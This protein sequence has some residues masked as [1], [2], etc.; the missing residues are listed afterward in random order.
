MPISMLFFLQLSEVVVCSGE[1]LSGT[2]TE[3]LEL[4]NDLNHAMREA[5]ALHRENRS[6]G[7]IYRDKHFQL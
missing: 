7:H 2:E 1:C 5:C 4:E 6:R 3:W